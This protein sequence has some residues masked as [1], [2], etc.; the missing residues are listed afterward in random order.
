[1]VIAGLLILQSGLAAEDVTTLAGKTYHFVKLVRLE[2]EGAVI[3]HSTG[4][5]RVGFSE[6]SAPER[7]KLSTLAAAP[8]ELPAITV[9]ATG[10]ARFDY[11]N[12]QVASPPQVDLAKHS[13]EL[14]ADERQKRL[15]KQNSHLIWDQKWWHAI[16]SFRLDLPNPANDSFMTPNY[17]KTEFQGPLPR[18][19]SPV[20]NPFGLKW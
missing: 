2:P 17:L 10:A 15:D 19:D 1:M 5:I 3:D 4:R 18:Q 6:L 11:K 13:L 16:P 14:Q 7:A 12:D 9:T 20:S 8:V